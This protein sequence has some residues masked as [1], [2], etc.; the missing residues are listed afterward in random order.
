MILTKTEARDYDIVAY[1]PAWI[2]RFAL[3]EAQL[4]EIFGSEVQVEHI[5]PTAV[6]GMSARP[7]I[8]VMVILEDIEQARTQARKLAM[9]GYID[10]GDR[11]DNGTRLFSKMGMMNLYAVPAGHE[12]AAIQVGFRDYMRS[13]PDIVALCNKTPEFLS[14]KF[15][16]YETAYSS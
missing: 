9:L 1:D 3:E 15:A 14:E 12:Y 6:A 2:R 5:G 16:E 13:N 10:K 8:D 4:K 11:L 7:A